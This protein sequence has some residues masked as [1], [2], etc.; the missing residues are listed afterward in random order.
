MQRVFVTGMGV[1]S[2]LGVGKEANL[3]RLCRGKGGIGRAS[4]FESKYTG[5]LFLSTCPVAEV[6]F[7]NLLIF[8]QR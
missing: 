1:I 5:S 6:S 8:G 3:D 4:V 7:F 2:S